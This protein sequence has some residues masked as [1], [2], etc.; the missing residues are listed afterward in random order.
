MLNITTITRK[1]VGGV[2]SYYADGADDYY[3]KDGQ[4][5]QWEGKGAEA[6]GLSGEVTQDRFRELL[7]GKISESEKLHRPVKEANKERLGYDLTFS[8]PKG[9][10]LQALVHGDHRIIQA[11][12]KAVKSAIAEAE[13]LAM[14][15]STTKGK[16]HIEHTG[17]LAVGTF[18][19]ETSRALDPDLHTH[20][21]VLNMTQREDGQWRALTNDGIVNSLSHL[22]NVYKA[23]LAKELQMQGF[24]LRFDRNGTFDLAHFS[25]DQIKGFSARSTQIEVALETKGLTRETATQEE[26]NLASLMTRE[27]KAEILN[28][29][30]VYANWQ[31]RAKELGIDFNSREWAGVGG[32][33]IA[34]R[35]SVPTN[36]AMTVEQNADR[37]VDFA[38]R[39][40]TERQAIVSDR[41]LREVAT[42]HGYGLVTVD[43]IRGAMERKVEGGHLIRDTTTYHPAANTTRGKGTNKEIEG[44]VLTRAEW[45][46]EME[47]TG[48]SPAEARRL[49]DQSIRNGR[50][51]KGEDRYTTH[52]AQRRERDILTIEQR[53][54]GVITPA[55]TLTE[56]RKFLDDKVARNPKNSPNAEQRTTVEAVVTTRNRFMCV[57]GYAGV[58]KSFMTGTAKEILE[59]QG[60]HVTGLAPYGSQVRN[61]QGDGLDSRTVASFVKAAD[62]KIGPESVVFIDEAGVMS[63]RQTKQVMSI[64]EQHGARAVFLGDTAQTKAIEAGKPFDQLMKAGAETSFMSTIQRQKENPELLKAV[65]Y[66]ADGDTQK[67]LSLLKNVAEIG[68]KEDRHNALA[69]QYTA[70]TKAE[71][72]KAIII[73]GTNES[74]QALNEGVRE[75]LGLAGKGHH[76][77]LMNRLDTTQEQRKHS[78]YYEKGAIVIPERDYRNGLKRGELYKVIDTG[79]GNRLTVKAPDGEVMSFSPSRCSKLDVYNIEKRELSP[80]DEVRIS[81]NVAAADL[82]THDRYQVKAVQKD[83]VLIENAA[84]KVAKLDNRQPLPMTYSY[85]TTVHSSQG[86]TADRVFANLDANSRTTQKEVYYVAVSRARHEVNV[87][88][89]DIDKLGKSIQ[90]GS[91]KNAALELRALAH[92]AKQQHEHSKDGA[93]FGKQGHEHQKTVKAHDQHQQRDVANKGKE[94]QHEQTGVGY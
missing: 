46:K 50:L 23:E 3:A 56:A 25:E 20:A 12:D 66:A 38:I 80:G 16:T 18:R 65:Q 54:R 2:V 15:R 52:I 42:K 48:R 78:R 70:L 87:Y 57:Q 62:K 4:S 17:N 6:L 26:K 90:R 51:Q 86:L 41:E 43:D 92:H 7:N 30:Q 33:E 94:K 8:A 45:I 34:D 73:T 1:S 74:R 85:A 64:I 72:E 71:R 82:G 53:G 10:S 28:R 37:C 77:E 13:R 58:G 21:F 89:N 9:V 35:N 59:A 29:E 47:G 36:R 44:P 11:H 49:V 27:K 24:E 91:D 19:H 14:A 60:Y 83:A 5:M 76:F 55:I 93:E 39:S 88:T 75:R 81:R 63:A 22:G 32:R 79:P 40:L 84:G 69:D 31:K 61:L 68:Q 67:S